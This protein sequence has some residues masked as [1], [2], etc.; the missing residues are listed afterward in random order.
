MTE[1]D[2]ARM[3][4]ELDA[5]NVRIDRAWEGIKVDLARKEWLDSQIIIAQNAISRMSRRRLR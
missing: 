2:I 3:Q 5:I 1:A 4:G